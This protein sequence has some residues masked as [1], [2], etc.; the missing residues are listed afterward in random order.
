VDSA[1]DSNTVQVTYISENNGKC[2][3][4]ASI[5]CTFTHALSSTF[6]Q[7]LWNGSSASTTACCSEEGTVPGI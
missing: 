4:S 6:Y 2:L 1:L 5:E 7:V 3:T